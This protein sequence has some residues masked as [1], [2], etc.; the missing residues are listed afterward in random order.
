MKRLQFRILDHQTPVGCYRFEV[1]KRSPFLWIFPGW[2]RFVNSFHTQDQ[3]IE[4]V[5]KAEDEFNRSQG[6]PI[7]IYRICLK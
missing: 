1:Q 2:W 3:A 6:L 5:Q 7:E 4:T